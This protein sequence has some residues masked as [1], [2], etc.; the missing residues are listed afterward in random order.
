MSRR[1]AAAPGESRSR[2]PTSVISAF[3]SA[4]PRPRDQVRGVDAE[5]GAEAVAA[6][7]REERPRDDD[8]ARG[9]A[10]AR[11]A[12]VEHGGQPPVAH[13]QVAD[14]DVAVQPDRVAVP[15]RCSSR[16]PTRAGRRRAGSRRRARRWPR[17]PRAR[18]SP[19]GRRGRSCARRAA[20]RRS[21]RR[22]RSAFRK[23]GEVGRE[24]GQVVDARLATRAPRR[25]SGRPTTGTG[26]RRRARPCATGV[27]IGSGSCGAS[28]GSQR[29][30][31]STCLAYQ[32]PLGSRTVSSEP[33]R[34]V[35]LS[36][37]STST[38]AIGELR[39]LRELAVDEPARQGDVDA[40][41]VR[42]AG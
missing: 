21:R 27:G 26:S 13:E 4:Q 10:D 30:S 17:G 11:R 14:R 24:R 23:P 22:G 18:R 41:P 37:P 15:R 3:H 5:L 29:C 8:V 28:T 1:G 7:A 2:Y 42:H 20:G 12:E 34:N 31:L 32:S 16:R 6:R 40:G 38:S 35:R 19:A 36:Q 33:S 39:P 9:V 25:A